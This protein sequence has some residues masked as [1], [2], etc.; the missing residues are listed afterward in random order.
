MKNKILVGILTTLAASAT[1]Y[2]AIAINFGTASGTL[3][4]Q[5]NVNIVAHSTFAAYWSADATIGF[6]NA[7]YLNPLGG[8]TYLGVFDISGGAAAAGRITGN[9]NVPFAV[10]SGANSY[11][12]I[13]VFNTLY[14]AGAPN[15]TAGT[16]YGVG[17]V[18][19]PGL[20]DANGSPTP[21]AD[22]YSTVLTAANPIQTSLQMTAVPEPA[23]FAF[24]GIGGLLFAIRRFRK[25]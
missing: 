23:T 2:A 7:N 19:G 20:A 16:Y 11:I 24:L 22:T 13:V 3:K 6:N 9:S 12:Y 17:P 15:I 1:S 21:P 14:N 8:D 25:S 4:D 5:A 18:L 10:P